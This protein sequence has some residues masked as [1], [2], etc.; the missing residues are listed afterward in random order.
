V[1]VNASESDVLA[2]AATTEKI[3][4]YLSGKTIKKQLYVPKKLVNFVV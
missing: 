1:D 4:P 2:L 3:I